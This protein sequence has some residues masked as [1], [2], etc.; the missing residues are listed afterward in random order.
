MAKNKLEFDQ[1]FQKLSELVNFKLEVNNYKKLTKKQK[2]QLQEKQ[3]N[4]VY[5]LEDIFKKS[6][7]NTAPEKLTSVY[8]K[9]I[10]YIRKDIGNILVSQ[11]Y[12]REKKT[13]FTK[14]SKC[15]KNDDPKGLMEFH[16]NYNLIAFIVKNWEDP[17]PLKTQSVY[18]RF[19]E[20]RQTLIE[21][22]IPLAINR[23]LLFYRK[24]TE[25]DLSL[26]DLV[27]IC[28]TGLTV[29]ID[30]YTGP[31]N[32]VWRSVCIGRMVGFMIKEYSETFVKLYPND[33]KI[34]YRANVIK[35]RK[36]I[37]DIQDLTKAVNESFAEDKKKGMAIPKLPIS[38]HTI[39]KLFNSVN[40]LSTD[41]KINE[42]SEQ[43]EEGV[44]VYNYVS[45]YEG[46]EGIADMA[47]DTEK[48]DLIN[49]L[50]VVIQDLDTVPR[51]IIKLKGVNV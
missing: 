5:E 26:L 38:S 41:S 7:R 12:F 9:F 10:T 36:K 11:S 28:I 40:Y 16:P 34:L 6:L 39:Q 17:L 2:D 15:I 13:S 29:G 47:E 18:D 27:N 44:G 35:Y 25:N 30:K 3:V 1:H 50:S 24:T 8:Q 46:Y 37:E 4:N 20:A 45:E 14:I 21:N 51:K 23:A 43:S 22:N 48:K 19:I 42:D 32:K 33:K 49:K 31:Y